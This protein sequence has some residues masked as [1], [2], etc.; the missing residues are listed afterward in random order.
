MA[1]FAQVKDDIVVSVVPVRNCAIGGCINPGDDVDYQADQHT[2]C[3]DLEYPAT[4]PLGQQFLAS[5]GLG[6]VWLQASYNNNFRA[7]YPGPGWLYDADADE[8]VAP[9][10]AAPVE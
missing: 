5:I 6:T 7:A 9:A 3:G 8:F 1:H 4:E 2:D 10:I